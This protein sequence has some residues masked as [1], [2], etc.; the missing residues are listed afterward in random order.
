MMSMKIVNKGGR[1]KTE[2]RDEWSKQTKKKEEKTKTRK[3]ADV[4]LN[5]I[6]Y[7]YTYFIVI[8]VCI[9]FSHR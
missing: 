7:C 8:F 2:K 4:R 1:T 5:V 6:T 3:T 9:A